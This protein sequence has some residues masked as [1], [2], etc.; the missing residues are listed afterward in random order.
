MKRMG[1]EKSSNTRKDA[2]YQERESVNN[3]NFLPKRITLD[4]TVEKES[5]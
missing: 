2:T 1:R 5:P 4:F 3:E